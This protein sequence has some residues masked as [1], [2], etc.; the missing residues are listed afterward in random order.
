MHNLSVITKLIMVLKTSHHGPSDAMHNLPSY[1]GFSQKKFVSSHRVQHASIIFLTSRSRYELT[2][3]RVI[4]MRRT[5]DETKLMRDWRLGDSRFDLYPGTLVGLKFW[6]AMVREVAVRIDC[7]LGTCRGKLAAGSGEADVVACDGDRCEG[8]DRRVSDG[9]LDYGRDWEDLGVRLG[10]RICRLCCL[11]R[12]D[13]IEDLVDEGVLGCGDDRLDGFRSCL[14]RGMTRRHACWADDVVLCVDVWSCVVRWM[15]NESFEIGVGGVR[16]I[17]VR[18]MSLEW[19]WRFVMVLSGVLYALEVWYGRMRLWLESDGVSF[20]AGGCSV[21]FRVGGRFCRVIVS[22]VRWGSSWD[23]EIGCDRLESVEWIEFGFWEFKFEF[24]CVLRSMLRWVSVGRWLRWGEISDV[25]A[26]LGKE[27]SYGVV[28][29]GS[30]MGDPGV[31]RDLQVRVFSEYGGGDMS[32]VRVLRWRTRGNRGVC[33]AS[34]RVRI[35][36]VSVGLGA[37][38]GDRG[39]ECSKKWGTG[40]TVKV[41]IELRSWISAC[42]RVPKMFI[43]EGSRMERGV[44][45]VKMHLDENE[46]GVRDAVEAGNGELWDRMSDGTNGDLCD[47]PQWDL[48]DDFLD[49]TLRVRV[50]TEGGGDMRIKIVFADRTGG[51]ESRGDFFDRID[52]VRV[53]M[54]V[55]NDPVSGI[56]GVESMC[57]GEC[58][59]EVF[60]YGK[61]SWIG[62]GGT[63]RELDCFRVR[64]YEM[65]DLWCELRCVRSEEREWRGAGARRSARMEIAGREIYAFLDCMRMILVS[66]MRGALEDGVTLPVKPFVGLIWDLEKVLFDDIERLPLDC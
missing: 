50:E 13:G 63:D 6:V 51:E 26:D 16:L 14:S 62:V 27:G 65:M 52:G 22:D 58:E 54:F 25:E 20:D 44:P 33:D 7:K 21:R 47:I 36:S 10:V 19:G 45:T 5:I 1:S 66:G 53:L 46:I 37:L 15:R 35:L 38:G 39:C 28:R 8:W 48:S 40:L 43:V 3:R 17:L 18:G 59:L 56:D 32:T 12:G 60:V 49:W 41:A 2:W 23:G 24:N 11:R 30:E 61:E 42:G 64:R 34:D 55:G 4:G 9:E 57:V 31:G 29:R